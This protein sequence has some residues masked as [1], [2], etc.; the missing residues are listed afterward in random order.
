MVEHDALR[1]VAG[2]GI[3]GDRYATGAGFWSYNPRHSSEV[4][5][6]E[7]EALECVSAALGVPFTGRESRRNVVTRN[8]S[9]D[10]LIGRRFRIDDAVFEGQR[11]C[12]PCGYLDE[13]LAKQVRVHF[14]GRGGLRARIVRGAV[15]SAG[16][17]IELVTRETLPSDRRNADC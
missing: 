9:L 1:A 6:V 5:F 15:F 4:T 16:S 12:D 3:E 13:L 17:A 2:A 8:V 11:P 7:C 10:E 14:E